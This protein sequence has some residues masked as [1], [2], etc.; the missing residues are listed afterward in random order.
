MPHLR[1]SD[2]GAIKAER[3]AL[4]ARQPHG[5]LVTAEEMVG[6]VAYLASPS[7]GSTTGVCLAVDGGMND[8]RLKSP[9][10]IRVS[11]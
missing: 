3:A 11:S 8:L 1:R 4:A 2:R 7:S 5:R 9:V 10:L 6:A